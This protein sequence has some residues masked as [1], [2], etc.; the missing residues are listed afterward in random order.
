MAC[1]VVTSVGFYFF[2]GFGDYF[3]VFIVANAKACFVVQRSV[4]PN[5]PVP[6]ACYRCLPKLL[7]FQVK[8]SRVS[9]EFECGPD[10]T[11]L[12]GSPEYQKKVDPAFKK[13]EPNLFTTI[14]YF[15]R[16]IKTINIIHLPAAPHF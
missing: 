6:V 3:A 10:E 15:W 13:L 16:P 8:K 1:S 4:C 9:V 2:I 12:Y 5:S 11:D 7:I 14:H